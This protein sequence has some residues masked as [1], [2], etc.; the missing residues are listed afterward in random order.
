MESKHSIKPGQILD[1]LNSRELTLQEKEDLRAY[2]HSTYNDKDLDELM[3]K[4]WGQQNGV[5]EEN[6]LYFNLLRDK[7]WKNIK[8]TQETQL[9]PD[10]RKNSWLSYLV[11]IAAILF[12]P[13][14][15]GSAFLYYRLQQANQPGQLVMQEVFATPGSRVSFTL[16][17]QT[18][19][20]L[21]SG[22]TIKYPVNFS[23]QNSRQVILS[24]QGYFEVAH[25]VDHP[26]VVKTSELNIQVL[27]TSFD[28]SSYADDQ[29]MSSTLEEG[30]IALL[31]D[32][33]KE[34]AKLKPGQKMILNKHSR[35]MFIEEV[36]TY[37]TTSWKDGKLI[38][39]KTPLEDVA[40][41][42]ERWF[43]CSIHVSPD[44]LNSN[45]LYT[46]TIQNE[47]VEE[48]LKMIEISTSVKTNIEKR[49]VTIWSKNE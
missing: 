9:E 30:S 12:I 46:A 34:I 11:R 7:I 38:F 24:G 18:K 17:D 44:L 6:D 1:K 32:E 37:L 15:I 10:F 49:E 23:N 16:P 36:D 45:I 3:T 8:K 33:G 41:R 28:V 31:N 4:H 48:V 26:F 21:N 13:L 25:D 2:I 47:T 29:M 35:K 14:L 42:L 43:N 19:V 27:G 39:K 20:W 40:I 5:V 22:S